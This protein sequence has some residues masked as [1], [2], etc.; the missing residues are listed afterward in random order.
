MDFESNWIE[1]HVSTGVKEFLWDEI[2]S[3]RPLLNLE[4]W[5]PD[6]LEE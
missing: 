1:M 6:G 4:E 2:M 5:K 3:K